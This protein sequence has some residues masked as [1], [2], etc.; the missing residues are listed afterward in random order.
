[1]TPLLTGFISK[2]TVSGKTVQK[3]WKG[4]IDLF[5]NPS[6]PTFTSEGT[7]IFDDFIQN[8]DG[9]T[10][11][12]SEQYRALTQAVNSG[13]AEGLRGRFS[14]VTEH[15]IGVIE[16]YNNL[17]RDNTLSA[18]ELQNQ[19]AALGEQASSST[20]AI[21]TGANGAEISLNNIA[22]T[23][24]IAKVKM[25]ALKAAATAL[26]A[27]MNIALS[28]GI[29]LLITKG[30]QMLDEYIHSAER[31]REA[32]VD[33]FQSANNEFSEMSKGTAKVDELIEKYKEL[34]SIP[35]SER[36]S[37][38]NEEIANI[39]SEI[40]DLVGNEVDNLELVNGQ[41]D[42]QIAKLKE[43]Q[44]IQS[45]KTTTSAFNAY[46]AAREKEE[47]AI[48]QHTSLFGDKIVDNAYT[49]S[50]EVIN[51]TK[52]HLNDK[53]L[54]VGMAYEDEK[55]VVLYD[56]FYDKNGNELDLS[57]REK[58]ETLKALQKEIE[59]TVKDY[60]KDEFYQQLSK[61]IELWESDIEDSKKAAKNALE[62]VIQ[63]TQLKNDSKIDNSDVDSLEEFKEYRQKIID[64]VTDNGKLAE[65]FDLGDISS[66][67]VTKYI[68]EYFSTLPSLEPYYKQWAKENEEAS[69]VV[70]QFSKEQDKVIRDAF[71]NSKSSQEKYANDKRKSKAFNSE[72]LRAAYEEYKAI[73][74]E[75]SEL[76]LE[77]TTGGKKTIFGNIDIK[78][79]NALEWTQENIEKYKQ[80]IDSWKLTTEELG[81]SSTVL[82][83]SMKF[84]GVE[85]AF[86]PML[87]VGD[88]SVL[89]DRNTVTEYMNELISEAK[90]DGN[91]SSDEL[92]KLDSAGI[93]KDGLQIK[94][95]IADIG[96]EAEKTGKKIS[97]NERLTAS[98][99]N[100]QSIAKSLGKVGRDIIGTFDDTEYGKLTEW[101]E[102]LPEEDRELV[103]EIAFN[104]KT[105]AWVLKDWQHE[106]ARI[107]TGAKEAEDAV[108]ALFNSDTDGNSFY[109]NKIQPYIDSITSLKDALTKVRGGNL[110]LTDMLA[111]FEKFPSLAG[112][113]ENLEHAIESLIRDLNAGMSDNFDEQI[114]Q[115]GEDAELTKEEL[116]ALKEL[117]LSMDGAFDLEHEKEVMQNFY[118]ALSESVSPTGL[119]SASIGNIKNMIAEVSS[120]D[121]SGLF[122]KTA[123]GIHL[124]TVKLAELRRAYIEQKKLDVRADLDGLINKY[125]ELQDKLNSGNLSPEEAIRGQ[126]ELGSLQKQI[127]EA[128]MLI[129]QYEGLTSAYNTWKQVEASGSERDMYEGVI[130][131]FKTIDDE[132]KRGW[133]D[134]GSIEFLKLLKGEQLPVLA[135]TEELIDAYESLDD[136]IK[137]TGYS[138]RDFFTVDADGNSTN[139]GVYNFLRAIQSLEEQDFSGIEGA[140]EGISGSDIVKV[141]ENGNY[142]IDFGVV[143]GDK[144]IAEALGISEEL[145]QI[146]ARA[147]DDAG[148]VVSMD[149]TLE[150]LSVVKERAKEAAEA[151]EQV[152][153]SG[154]KYFQD[155]SK[156]TVLRDYEEATK[157][158]ST[159][160]QNLNE[161]GTV[162]MTVEGAET[163]YELVS[164]LLTMKMELEDPSYMELDSS[165][166]ETEMQ[167]PLAK[168][169]EYRELTKTEEQLKLKGID[170]SSIEDSKKE[171]IQYF[172]DLENE[173]PTLY[174][175]LGLEGLTEEQIMEKINAGEIEVPV[176]IDLQVETNDILK[177][178]VNVALLNAGLITPEEFEKRVNI[179]IYAEEINTEEAEQQTEETINNIG[180]ETTTVDQTVEVNTTI[181]EKINDLTGEKALTINVTTNL[182]DNFTKLEDK[183]NNPPKIDVTL[184]GVPDE[185]ISKFTNGEGP[186]TY[187]AT[188]NIA[189]NSEELDA[190]VESKKD[191]INSTTATMKVNANTDPARRTVGSFLSYVSSLSSTVTIRGN[192]SPLATDI[193]NVLNSPRTITVRANVTGLPSTATGASPVDGSAYVSGTAFANGTR[194]RSGDW[195][196]GGIGGT[197]LVGELGYEI[198]VRD[199]HFFTIGDQSAEF[200]RYR[201]GDI[202][203]NHEQAEQI[204]EKGRIIRGNKRGKAFANGTT[205]HAIGRA[206]S[207]NID[208]GGVG[209]VSG[210]PV[211]GDTGS[212][213][214]GD[215]TPKTYDTGD[216]GKTAE[217]TLETFDWIEI[218]IQ[219]IE[220]AIASLERKA[221]A[222]YKTFKTRNTQ[223]ENQIAKVNEEI[224]VQQQA[225]DEYIKK[226]NSIGLK[227]EYREKVQNGTLQIEDITNDSLKEKIQKYQ[228][229]Y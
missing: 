99:D 5:K 208:G 66:E 133:L 30:I 127:E 105:S 72:E 121:P 25:V 71:F 57:I 124:N 218:K 107:K 172:K 118:T 76:G 147:A 148:F 103:Y 215:T 111:L 11:S 196:V 83:D 156:E 15:D 28:M 166:V 180:N 8:E 20:R 203:F 225:Y 88:K 53:Q 86:S 42:E 37:Q 221:N 90:K 116:E 210:N 70:T 131:G 209:D 219:Q 163:A 199:G 132:L 189:G 211:K 85:I 22:T 110:G 102:T 55:Q 159:Y 50:N 63:D 206:F 157:E 198:L 17:V 161:D 114:R 205:H 182:D 141:D 89:L 2:F 62:S 123:N 173:N 58:V 59:D 98:K 13:N 144:V 186:V 212:G 92:L 34:K 82:G 109:S 16:Q 188:V 112:K 122:E 94:G 61:Q 1:M 100:M 169:Q 14:F 220:R 115:L 150:E 65:M 12:F 181:E 84:A 213:S 54:S 108:T 192:T 45:E 170:T 229:W 74:A 35:L 130:G 135:T 149:G 64:E 176:A 31:A 158:W 197:A 202:I 207:T 21:I 67:D 185:N 51:I 214:K 223:L 222:A 113:S 9:T 146:M 184:T 96:D 106:F 95:L 164:G 178:L 191:E 183:T 81:S 60:G 68:D 138:I 177:D 179:N 44:A 228:E 152:S 10:R 216:T 23:T 193:A 143:G 137:N 91:F 139:G 125:G 104:E 128:E 140:I 168:L 3:T 29:S 26:G 136:K 200:I 227:K 32:S 165:Q 142:S 78:D 217:Q 162:D 24:G 47:T 41:L 43:A 93:E 151:V 48:A 38:D 52:K 73:Y 195:S 174:A 18:H 40:V 145:V 97:F 75:A 201:P 27:V 187:D 154:Y 19:I 69:K 167:T 129:Y 194:H 79:R 46:T 77:K 36:T 39:Q 120:Y 134:E 101:Y 153:N 224:T 56:K 117:I 190:S 49:S 4:L 171:I 119:S 226:A 160:Q 7:S 204:L 33:A 6:L 155:G 126:Y 175:D 87:Q 80:A